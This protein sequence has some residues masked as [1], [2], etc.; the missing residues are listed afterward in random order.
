MLRS[1]CS[2][3]DTSLKN[4]FV[5]EKTSGN[6]K[7]SPEQPVWETGNV[8]WLSIANFFAVPPPRFF[9][10]DLLQFFLVSQTNFFKEK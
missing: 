9:L 10:L 1:S 7:Y 4:N 6:D 8:L 5:A 2:L 3:C